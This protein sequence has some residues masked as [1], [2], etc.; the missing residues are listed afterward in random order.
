[1]LSTE[2]LRFVRGARQ[3]VDDA[4][5]QLAWALNL[6]MRI[7]FSAETLAYETG[8]SVQTVRQLR[9]RATAA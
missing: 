3:A 5:R 9:Q 1:M 7:G 6:A 4:E 8:L 2:N